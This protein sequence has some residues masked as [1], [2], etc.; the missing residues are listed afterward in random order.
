MTSKEMNLNVQIPGTYEN[1][2]ETNVFIPGM[3]KELGNKGGAWEQINL[4]A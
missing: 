4:N 2:Y 3:K 1:R